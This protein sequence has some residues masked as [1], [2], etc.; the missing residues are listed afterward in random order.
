MEDYVNSLII[1]LLSR[2][3]NS[4]YFVYVIVVSDQLNHLL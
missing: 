4:H 1:L 2:V 3:D